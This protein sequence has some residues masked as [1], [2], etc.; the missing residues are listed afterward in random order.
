M[1]VTVIG[2]NIEECRMQ[3]G[4]TGSRGREA[5][6]GIRWRVY[7]PTDSHQVG[8]VVY[9]F[10]RVPREFLDTRSALAY[11]GSVLSQHNRKIRA[12]NK[13]ERKA[14]EGRKVKP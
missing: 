9:V 8:C 14:A 12:V 1:T 4:V 7:A 3:L 2:N 11:I 13:T 10:D 6:I 5:P